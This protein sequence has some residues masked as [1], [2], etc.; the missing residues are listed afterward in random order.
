MGCGG[1][2][3]DL[4]DAEDGLPAADIRLSLE[5]A[6][7]AE[8]GG[9]EG[10]FG[11]AVVDGSEVPVD[12]G[13]GGV[14]VKLISNVYQLLDGGDVDVIHRAKVEDDGFQSRA[15][16]LIC[17]NCCLLAFAGRRVIP[18][19]ISWAVIM[20]EVGSAGGGK[21]V[22]RQLIQVV[23]GIWIVEAFAKAVNKD[24]RVG[25][26]DLDIRVGAIPVIDWQENIARR[27]IFI[28]ASRLGEVAVI[29]EA[30]FR[31]VANDSIAGH[32][33]DLNFAQESALRLNDSKY[34][35]CKRDANC[36]V[37]T[38]FD[39]RKDGDQYTGKEDGYLKGRH[40]PELVYGVW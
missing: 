24:S 2:T 22:V 13:W 35:D 16:S 9:D 7:V 40:A 27:R 3:S 17:G 18:R 15:I 21:D 39:R 34:Q 19:V 6:G 32:G 25:Y 38:V 12:D 30:D 11:P 1:G 10:A 8:A 37:Y 14:S 36:S 23:I 29:G 26:S 5:D 20:V 33:V 4:C 31:I 28:N